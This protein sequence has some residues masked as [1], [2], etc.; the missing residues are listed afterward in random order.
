MTKRKLKVT[1]RGYHLMV[2]LA[3]VCCTQVRAQKERGD[4]YLLPQVGLNSSYISGNKM[5]V[6]GSEV[7]EKKVESS[8]RM[9]FT[10]GCEA[11]YM[12]GRGAGVRLGLFYSEQGDKLKPEE[13]GLDDVN[14]RLRYLC[15]PLT[16][17][18]Y[19]NDY[20]GVSVGLQYSRLLSA[21]GGVDVTEGKNDLS[22]PV[23]IQ[24]EY[25]NV[26]LSARYVFGLTDIN[27]SELV[28]ASY[29]N[30]SLW[31]TVGYRIRL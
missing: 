28:N 5:L 17:S 4:I 24:G 9:G 15:V 25:R 2:L 18:L 10:A 27:K 8:A 12:V 20:I 7:M 31:V 14:S 26:L 23:G 16:L 3:L 21:D 11:E 22:I 30:R 6:N 19:A 29:H 1:M 13:K